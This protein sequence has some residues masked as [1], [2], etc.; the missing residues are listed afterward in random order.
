MR[1]H[2]FDVAVLG[3]GLGGS[4]LAAILARLG[5]RVLVLERRSLPRPYL[6][7]SMPRRASLLLWMLAQR[8][9][10]PEVF[11]LSSTE[12][13]NQWAVATSGARRACGF[14]YHEPGRPHPAAQS[15]LVVPPP[16]PF[17]SESH[18]FR[19]D[20]DPYLA[21]AARGY[22]AVHQQAARVVGLDLVP[23]GVVL[24]CADGAEHLARFVVDDSGRQAPV[25]ACF[26]LREEPSPLRTRTR[27]IYTD[28]KELRRY[29][30]LLA[31]GELAGLSRSWF[32]GTLH[33]T[34]EGGTFWVIPFDNDEGSINPLASVG[35]TLDLD[36]FPETVPSPQG[37]LDY[38]AGCFPSIAAHFEGAVPVRPWRATG[39]L[40]FSARRSVAERCFLLPGSAAFVDR[41]YGGDLGQTCEVLYALLPRLLEA[42]G[43]DDPGTERF[44]ELERYQAAQVQAEDRWMAL[45]LRAS[46]HYETWKAWLRV[47]LADSV[48][49]EERWLDRCERF[50]ETGDRDALDPGPE[51][52]APDWEGERPL[53]LLAERGEALMA[54]VARRSLAPEQAAREILDALGRAPLPPIYPAVPEVVGGPGEGER[55]G[56]ALSTPLKTKRP[57]RFPEAA[58]S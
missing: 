40:Q 9:D 32:Q 43:E 35:V 6:R 5:L 16:L 44:A 19:R 24:T 36:R 53:D 4:V 57:P 2:S 15:Q 31:D 26:G 55:P 8:Y 17:C 33:H 27:S 47:W 21:A 38:L 1:N 18:L 49:T 54:A 3:P 34:F 46:A 41:F 25:A 20:V 56:G 22:G 51:D 29:D 37:E 58:P 12:R 50:L 10:V 23:G 11:A 45:S 30:E 14:L 7:E 13:L 52:L 48:F 28:V 42:L 39:R